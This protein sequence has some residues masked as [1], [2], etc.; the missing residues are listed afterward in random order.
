[1]QKL[2]LAQFP[3]FPNSEAS[4]FVTFQFPISVIPILWTPL[5]FVTFG[6]SRSLDFCTLYLRAFNFQAES[7]K[8]RLQK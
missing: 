5:D 2:S 4:K 3:N 8:I 1:M 6:I 7:K